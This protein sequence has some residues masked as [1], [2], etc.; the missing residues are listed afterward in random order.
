[1]VAHAFGGGNRFHRIISC[2]QTALKWKL[3]HFPEL[4]QWTKGTIALLG[5]ATHP[6]LPYQGQGAAMAVEDGAILGLL[7]ARMQGRGLP[8]AAEERSGRLAAL[9]KL[10]EDLRKRRTEVNVAG[11][12]RTKEFYHLG[13]GDTQVERDRLLAEMPA[14]DWAG[15]CRWNWA[16]GPYQKSLLG[17]DVL[18]DA[19]QRFDEW[20]GR[21]SG[22]KL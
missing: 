5:D 10:Y 22:G 3:L 2:L 11:A 1:M 9:L 20:V 13:D 12:V 15:P 16:D 21:G 19:E 17:F 4:D 14:T 6:T 18:A 8:A 7:L